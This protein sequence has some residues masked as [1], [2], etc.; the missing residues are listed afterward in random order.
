MLI[1]TYPCTAHDA[2]S[3]IID[4]LNYHRMGHVKPTAPTRKVTGTTWEFETTMQ[5]L[6][7]EEELLLHMKFSGDKDVNVKVA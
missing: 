2:W 3:R 5:D 4:A 1:F 6:T 7:S